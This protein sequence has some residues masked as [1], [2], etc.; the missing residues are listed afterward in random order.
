VYLS[1]HFSWKNIMAVTIDIP[2][3]GNVEAKNAASEATL[4]A[5]LKAMTGVQKNTAGGGGGS[6]GGN[7][8][9]SAAGGMNAAG[10]AAHQFGRSLGAAAKTVVS[11]S[12]GVVGV[13]D[14]LA[15]MGDSIS[16]AAAVFDK[17]PIV[18]TVFAAVAKAVENTTAA[19]QGAAQSGATFGGSI[20]AFAGAASSAGMTMKDFSS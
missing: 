14:R 2:G 16:G 6:G 13:I 3:V 9:G 4:Q 17:I 5:I 18:G 7:S 15:N 8:G 11:F 19:Y 12:N 20:N 1:A 10:T